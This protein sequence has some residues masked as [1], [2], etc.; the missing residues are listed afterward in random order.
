MPD[1][2]PFKQGNEVSLSWSL[3]YESSERPSDFYPDTDL[4]LV[5][6]CRLTVKPGHGFVFLA[7]PR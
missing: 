6:V 3:D 2:S 5:E 4:E 7:S 1:S